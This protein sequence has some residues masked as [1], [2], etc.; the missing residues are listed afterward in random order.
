[1]ALKVSDVRKA[2]HR[3]RTMTRKSDETLLREARDTSETKFEIF[4]SHS[5][6][7]R[8]LVLGAKQ[9]IEESDRTVYVDWIDDGRLDRSQVDEERAAFLRM[10]MRQCETLFYAHSRNAAVSRWCPWELG[11]FDAMT[12]PDCQ[13]LVLPIVEDGDRFEGQEYLGLYE[14]VDLGTYRHRPRRVREQDQFERDR[15]ADLLGM[16]RPPAL[17]RFL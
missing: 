1:M 2:A 7:D 15:L 17:R 9:L 13:V 3:A 16:R 5:F 10:R 14:T 6:L 11:Y 12:H 4:L 8:E